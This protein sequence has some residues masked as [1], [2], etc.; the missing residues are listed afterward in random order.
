MRGGRS[1][2]TE[3]RV[4]VTRLA[5]LVRL[6]DCA[7]VLNVCPLP[8]CAQLGSRK[9]LRKIMLLGCVFCVSVVL[10]NVSLRYI[11]VSFNQAIGATTPFFTAVLAFVVQQRIE[12]PITYLTLVPV[13]V[14][15]VVATQAEPLFNMIGF[16]AAVAATVARAFKS[17]LQ[18]A[19]LS[20]EEE[21][22]DSQNLLRYMAP[23][24]ACLLLPV[25][26]IFEGPRLWALDPTYFTWSLWGLLV[27]NACT[28]YFVNLTN[29]LVTKYTSALT[30]QVLG[31]AKG[32]VAVAVSVAIFKNPLTVPSVVGY[33][34]TLAGVV[35]YSEQK[36]RSKARE[37]SLPRDAPGATLLSR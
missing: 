13:V 15:V 6:S 3:E 12:S 22:I 19:L 20:S 34:I 9:Q 11:P 28:A 37:A 21:K 1:A 8:L 2:Y 7:A 30:L 24:A 36:R 26:L 17:V 14:G 16:C 18:G 35:A 25:A 5:A 32:A 23:T 10:G 4:V 33:A 29:F 31:N 27:L